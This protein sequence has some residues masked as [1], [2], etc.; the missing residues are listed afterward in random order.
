LTPFPKSV[1]IY[2]TIVHWITIISSIAALFVPIFMLIDPSNNILN[3]NGIF[4]A[5]LSGASPS[6]I[7][8][9][10]SEGFLP[11]PRYYLTNFGSTDSWAQLTITLGCSVSL[12]ALI[13]TVARQIFK[14]KNYFYAFLGATLAVLTFFSM[15]GLLTY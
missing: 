12:W 2:S 5:I 8:A 3:P 6:E 1:L 10:S 11:G 15:T 14:E 7:W 9:M 4:S 13:P